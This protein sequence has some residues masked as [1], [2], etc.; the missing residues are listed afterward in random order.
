M[1]TQNLL[2][3]LFVE[4]LPPKALQKLGDAFAT[5][6]GDQLKA[7]GLATAASVVTPFASPRRLAAH[8]TAV[9]DKAAD[10]AVQQKLMPVTVGLDKDGNP[11]PALLKK[12]QALGADVSNPAAAVAALKRAQDG[13][14]EALFY[15]SVVPGAT[16]AA[17]L[18]KAL[19]EAIAKL[20][21][22]KVMSY[23][24]ETDC[25][26]PGWT[27]V[28]FVRPAHGL[29][30]LHGST[31]VPVKALGLTAGNSTTGH[32]FEAAV[33][34]V[35]L[36]DAD[37][38]AATLKK[39]GAVIASFAERKAEI[40]RQLA[41]AAA[42]VGNGARPIEDEAL[43]DEVTALV[44]RPNVVI[45]QFEE[46]FLGV[47]Q[48]CLILTMKANQKYFPLLDA[49]GKLTNK[50][51]VVSNISPEDTSFVT[52]GNERVVRPRLADAKFFFDQ[53]RKKTLASR[54]E[55]L[56]KVVYHN[57]LGTQGERVERVRAIAKAIATQLGD[58]ALVADADQAALLAK[59]DLVTDMVGEFPE[60]Q[61]IMGG[62]YALNDGLGEAVAHAIEDH[63]KPRFAGDALPRNTAGVVVAL[64]DKLETLVGMF[65]IGNLPTGDRDPFALRRHALGVIRMLVEKDLPLDLQS[66]VQSTFSIFGE[67]VFASAVSEK[68]VQE[69][70]AVNRSRG[71]VQFGVA[72]VRVG[73]SMNPTAAEQ[74]TDFI[75]DRLAGS[76]REQGYS[77]Q[78]VDAVLALR[79]QRLALVEKQ[80]AAVRAFAALPESPALAAANKR[81]GNILKKAEVEGPVDA[82]VN[83][84]LL[85]EKAEQDLYAALQRFVPEANAQFDAGDY[86]ASLQTL[87]VLRAPVD[88][89]FDDVMVN[90]EQLDVRMNRLGLLKMLH[91][92]M[93]RV[94]DLSRLAV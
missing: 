17:G 15:D 37:S 62:Y 88:A 26:L 25:E 84:E 16:L 56:G 24:L 12:L 85:Q 38:Y 31:V 33:S 14:A 20:P 35:V 28:N 64:A 78:E 63:Y 89:F 52:G 51:L 82:H 77:A 7:Q 48:E 29:V 22:P 47:P 2:V 30:A 10:K 50:F 68:S 60:L 59:T 93:N 13:K 40:A 36:A 81:V 90:A 43:L 75:Y 86:T 74:L 6:L 73:T 46:Q 72:T 55:G 44:E 94:A 67:Q 80:L 92:A 19:D 18:Q 9:A 70:E 69:M 66:L 32:R 58:A 83:P 42:K 4:E 54:V 11:T 21:I 41:A 71:G 23:Q 65:G 53:D 8:V 34:P 87:A 5:V 1:T 57:K 45:C 91:N 3:E 79:P 39:D 27:S 61:G 49:A 76:L